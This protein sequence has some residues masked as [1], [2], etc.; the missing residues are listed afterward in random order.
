ME[1]RE[2]FIL[3]SLCKRDQKAFRYLYEQ[4]FSKMILFAESYV[5]D[6]EEAK[7]L[8]QDLFFLYLGSCRFLVDKHFFESL[9][10][11]FFA[12]PLSECLA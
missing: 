4:Y 6:E 2:I 3:K 9:F 7:D 12:E 8:V 5:Y 10:V 1:D 11:Y